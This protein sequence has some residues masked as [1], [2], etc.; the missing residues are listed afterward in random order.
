MV[1]ARVPTDNAVNFPCGDL[2][3]RQSFFP[4]RLLQRDQ[5]PAE[6]FRRWAIARAQGYFERASGSQRGPSAWS[7]GSDLPITRQISQG[8]PHLAQIRRRLHLLANLLGCGRS[9]LLGRCVISDEEVKRLR[10]K[11]KKERQNKKK[12]RRRRKARH[13]RR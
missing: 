5:R 9:P 7:I 8:D 2:Q 10:E 1:V 3:A 4:D 13:R 6:V 11:K 12:N